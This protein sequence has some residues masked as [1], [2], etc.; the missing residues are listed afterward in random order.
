MLRT[1]SYHDLHTNSLIQIF[2]E[3]DCHLRPVFIVYIPIGVPSI[4]SDS[5]RSSLSSSRCTG[6]H[7]AKRVRD[8]I[9][10][11]AVLFRYTDNK[12]RILI[13]TMSW[14]FYYNGIVQEKQSVTGNYFKCVVQRFSM[15]TRLT[16][17]YPDGFLES[18]GDHG[19]CRIATH[20]G[21]IAVTQ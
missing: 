13:D 6:H 3:T 10:R 12:H 8:L 1:I 17:A 11:A 20:K 4:L 21:I 15:S 19:Q 18:C 14:G 2:I 16:I 7:I 9:P 5:H